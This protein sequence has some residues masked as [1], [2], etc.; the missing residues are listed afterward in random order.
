MNKLH[1]YPVAL[2]LVALVGATSLLVAAGL[3]EAAPASVSVKHSGD[4]VRRPSI[5][6]L[7]VPTA[8]SAIRRMERLSARTG[9]VAFR[10]M[11]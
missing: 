4:V 6:W 8:R 10:E 11:Q 7:L 2:F 3:S 9:E 1:V 5:A